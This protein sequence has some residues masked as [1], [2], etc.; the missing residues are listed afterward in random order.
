[1]KQSTG[2]INKNNKLVIKD[3]NNKFEEIS[4]SDSL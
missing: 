1:M 4:E 2:I 3:T